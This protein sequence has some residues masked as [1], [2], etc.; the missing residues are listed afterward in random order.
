MYIS[1]RDKWTKSI[2]KVH[3]FVLLLIL[4]CLKPIHWSKI[5]QFDKCIYIE[6]EKTGFEIR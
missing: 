5:L 3:A 6:K 1:H 2:K 4:I